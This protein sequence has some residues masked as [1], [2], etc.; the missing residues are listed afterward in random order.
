[1]NRYPNE[2]VSKRFSVQGQIEHSGLPA[3]EDI[4]PTA[5]SKL[6]RFKI[7]ADDFLI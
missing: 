2:P 6:R 3:G 7:G 4:P 5:G 1:M